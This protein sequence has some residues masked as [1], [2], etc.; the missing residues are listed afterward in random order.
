M[1]C[2]H[3]NTEVIWDCDYDFDDPFVGYDGY[4]IVSIFHCPKC[5]AEYECRL[6]IK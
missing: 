1:K 4:G 3:C 2:W 6:P 5:E